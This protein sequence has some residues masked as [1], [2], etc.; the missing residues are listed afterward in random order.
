MK[1]ELIY[2]THEVEAGQG[3]TYSRDEAELLHYS[4]GMLTEALELNQAVW[5]WTESHGQKELDVTNVAEELADSRWYEAG[6]IRTLGL[7]PE[8]YMGN[9]IKKLQNRFPDGF[10]E[11]NAKIK[12][13]KL[14]EERAIL[15]DR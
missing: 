15:E 5:D 10:S 9:N 2:D 1:K 6:F 11:H 12:N 8:D 13:R 3:V 7:D 14:D 4:I